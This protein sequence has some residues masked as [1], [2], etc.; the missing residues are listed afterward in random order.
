MGRAPLPPH[1][2]G[3]ASRRRRIGTAA[4]SLRSTPLARL[5][6][7]QGRPARPTALDAFA[8]ARKQWLAGERLDIGQL[9]KTLGVGRGTLFRWVGS[10]EELYGEV[11]SSLFLSELEAARREARGSGH[12]YVAA[13]IHRLLATLVDSPPLRTFVRRDPEFAMRVLVSHQSPV[14]RRNTAAIAEVLAAEAGAGRLHLAMPAHDLAY[15]I[16]RITE[17]FLYRDVIAGGEPDMGKAEIAICILLRA[18]EA[19]AASRPRRRRRS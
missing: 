16:V 19:P 12:A 1:K 17:S 13:V 11:L 14:V 18:G 9:A 15:L 3:G 2:P 10:R 6:E 5:I 8:L 7:T 4:R